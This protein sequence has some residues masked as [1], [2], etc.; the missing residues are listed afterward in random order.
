MR[1]EGKGRSGW[2]GAGRDGMGWDG[3]DGMGR[4]GPHGG[5]DG[6]ECDG[7]EGWDTGSGWGRDRTGWNAMGQEGKDGMGRDGPP[8]GRDKMECDVKGGKGWNGMGQDGMI[9]LMVEMWLDRQDDHVA[10]HHQLHVIHS[11]IHAPKSNELSKNNTVPVP[12]VE[13]ENAF[14]WKAALCIRDPVLFLPLDPGWGKNLNP[15]PGMNIPD[16][17]SDSL[18]TIFLY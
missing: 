2:G 4:D 5:R 8:G 1:W 11:E 14:A 16:H 3:K 13:K 15:D 9:H 17:F 10:L 6:V 7:R 12:V 18:E